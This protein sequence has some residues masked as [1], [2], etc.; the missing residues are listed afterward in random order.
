[1]TEK[2]LDFIFGQ[3]G[4]MLV[5]LASNAIVR[6]VSFQ[7]KLD[8]MILIYIGYMGNHQ[9]AYTR[10]LKFMIVKTVC[11]NIRKS[12]LPLDMIGSLQH[13]HHHLPVQDAMKQL[14]APLVIVMV[15]GTLQPVP[16]VHPLEQ[17]EEIV[18]EQDVVIM[19]QIAYQPLDITMVHGTLQPVPHAHPRELKEGIVH[20]QDAVITRQTV[21]LHLDIAMAHGI[22]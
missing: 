8:H 22:L 12:F 16:H 17:K 1:M 19:R 9:L 5:L 7:L 2:I 6:F 18:H 10:E 13:V 20:V 11:M 15:H 4:I 14:E 3:T 21:Y